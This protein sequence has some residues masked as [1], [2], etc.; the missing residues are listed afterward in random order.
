MRADLRIVS[1]HISPM[2]VAEAVALFLQRC[3]ARG[4]SPNTVNAYGCDLRQFAGFVERQGQGTLVALVSTRAVDRWLDE[5]SATGCTP[6]TQARKL[7]GLRSF[8]KFARREGWLGHDPTADVEVRFRAKRVVA[9]ELEALHSMVNAIGRQSPVDLRDRAMLRL[10]LDAGLRISETAAVDMP[11]MGSQSEI[12]LPR[13]LVHVVG[14]GGDTETMCFNATTRRVVEEWLAVRDQMADPGCQALFVTAR[15]HRCS[16][17]TLHHVVQQRGAAV[18]LGR[19]HWHLMRHRRIAMV[20]ERCG[21]KLGQQFGRHASLAT[22]SHYG[23][24]ADNTTFAVLRERA[25]IDT[26]RVYA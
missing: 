8:V 7:S 20:I 13:G 26:A 10:A 19:M 1:N 14:K 12:D 23:R 17:Q 3:A 4:L 21:D 16:R 2:P 6:R 22:T 9:P 18:G 5:L 24:H 25:D 11:G 15:G